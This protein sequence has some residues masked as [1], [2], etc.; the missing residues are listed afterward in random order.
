MFIEKKNIVLEK[1]LSLALKIIGLTSKLEKVNRVLANQLLRSGTSV[2]VN[3]NEAQAA[4]SK[5][6]FIA[7]VSIA[8]KEIRETKYWLYLVFTSNLIEADKE[9]ENLVEEII[10]LTTSIIKTAQKEN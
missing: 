9:I 5:K 2:G 10:K 6:E 3:L 1:S 7:K 8:A 4:I